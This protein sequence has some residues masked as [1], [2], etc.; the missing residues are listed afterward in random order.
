M[1]LAPVAGVMLVV[2][3]MVSLTLPAKTHALTFEFYGL[4]Y[5][6]EN[7]HGFEFVN[8]IILDQKGNLYWNTSPVTQAELVE[9]LQG[10]QT[11]PVT[12]ALIYAPHALAPYGD[13]VRVL[14]IIKETGTRSFCVE[15]LERN[16]RFELS[17]TAPETHAIPGFPDCG[18][19][20]TA[21]LY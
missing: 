16:R 5:F 12:P 9:L 17:A 1:S 7:G 3:A 19:W 21:P 15:G 20:D 14:A 6:P 10:S 8:R 13:A 4:D 18:R 2:G 11:L